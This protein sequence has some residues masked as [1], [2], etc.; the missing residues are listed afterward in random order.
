MKYFEKKELTKFFKYLKSN[1]SVRDQAIYNIMYWCGLRVS[2]LCNM[3][4]DAYNESNHTLY[5]KR[6]KNGVSNTVQ[7]DSTRERLVRKYLKQRDMPLEYDPLFIS[8]LDSHLSRDGIFKMTKKLCKEAKIRELSP[9]AFRH[10][11]AVHL[12]DSEVPIYSVKSHL[13][14]KNISSTMEY[15]AYTTVQNKALYE[16]MVNSNMIA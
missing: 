15:L 5:C 7:L 1:C 3:R 2:E 11:I 9:H 16:K 14:H 8:R 4:V 13:G 12:L 10:S 6:S